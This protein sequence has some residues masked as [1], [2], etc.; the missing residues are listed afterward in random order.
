M[1]WTWISDDRRPRAWKRGSPDP[2][3]GDPP[4]APDH[5]P[6]QAPVKQQLFHKVPRRESQGA[7][8]RLSSPDGRTGQAFNCDNPMLKTEPQGDVRQVPPT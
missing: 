4:G 6:R 2:E 8:P 3:P 5:A 1:E 7:T